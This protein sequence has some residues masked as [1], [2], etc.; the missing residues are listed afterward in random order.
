MQARIRVLVHYIAV[1]QT[2]S[3]HAEKKHFRK[4]RIDRKRSVWRKYAAVR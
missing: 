3:K 2:A 4:A 1:M